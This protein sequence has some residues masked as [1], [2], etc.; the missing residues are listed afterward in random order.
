[1]RFGV[2]LSEPGDNQKFIGAGEKAI[3]KETEY[4]QPF[5]WVKALGILFLQND[6]FR[7]KNPTLKKYI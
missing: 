3:G 2:A 6:T 1:M 7:V 4:L 5:V